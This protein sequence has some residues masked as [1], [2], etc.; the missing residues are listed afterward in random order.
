MTLPIDK[1]KKNKIY[2]HNTGLL[3]SQ[4]QKCFYQVSHMQHKYK[5]DKS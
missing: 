3:F 5:C 2:L 4:T 1:F